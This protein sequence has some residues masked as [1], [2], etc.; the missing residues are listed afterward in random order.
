MFFSIILQRTILNQFKMHLKDEKQK[1]TVNGNT[2][3]NATSIRDQDPE[4]KK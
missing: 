3:E 4:D 2:Y 1:Y